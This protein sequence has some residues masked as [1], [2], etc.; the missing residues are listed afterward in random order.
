MPPAAAEAI[1]IFD[2]HCR[3]LVEHVAQSDINYKSGVDVHGRPVKP[4]DVAPSP[5]KLPETTS[6]DISVDVFAFLR[7]AA[8]LDQSE[9]LARDRD[10]PE[11]A[12]LLRMAG[13]LDRRESSGRRRLPSKTPEYKTVR[14]RPERRRAAA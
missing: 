2:A 5:I 14:R 1:V 3:A 6:V 10:V 12:R 13:D 8:G 11:R 4:A 7:R 9:G